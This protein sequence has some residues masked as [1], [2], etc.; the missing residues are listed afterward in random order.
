MLD[1]VDKLTQEEMK[2]MNEIKEKKLNEKLI[3]EKQIED[4]VNKKKN[5]FCGNR[6]I[7]NKLSNL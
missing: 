7:D 3:R 2:K 5:E 6:E 4:N 1:T